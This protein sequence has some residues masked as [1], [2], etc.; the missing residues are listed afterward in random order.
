MSRASAE[1]RHD[2]PIA[3]H[4]RAVA[5][6][7]Y[8]RDAMERAGA[9]TAV[10]GW[11]GVGM[12]VIGLAAA[13]FAS[14]QATVGGWLAVWSVAAAAAIAVACVTMVR[15]AR[16]AGRSLLDGPGQKFALSFLPPLVAGGV[17]TATLVVAGAIE[18]VP[19]VWLL[20]YGASV[21]AAGSFSVRVVPIMGVCFMLLGAAAL[22]GPRVWGD[23]W[24]AAGF[25]GLQIAFGLA[26]AR[27]YGG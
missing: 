11:G 10:P 22:L 12:G 16:R 13:L 6:L 3:L 8:I 17:L 18:F 1:R 24:L 26:I 5:D 7:R 9:F 4:D 20:L 23:V 19:G 14:R 2:E 25:G 27:W 21:A 15:K